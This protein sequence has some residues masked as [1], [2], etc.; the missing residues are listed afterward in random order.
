MFCPQVVVPEVELGQ[1]EGERQEEPERRA[2]GPH[3]KPTHC[4]T[5]QPLEGLPLEEG[6]NVMWVDKHAWKLRWAFTCSSCKV[7]GRR[8]GKHSVM[9][10]V[11][12]PVNNARRQ[13]SQVRR[14]CAAQ[15]WSL[16]TV[17]PGYKLLERSTIFLF[18]S[19]GKTLSLPRV[20]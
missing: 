3:V 10:D 18:I 11:E 9:G 14:K 8:D 12:L 19:K 20:R 13:H 15:S 4:H 17:H 2:S 5:L 6:E 16:A 1:V 7:V